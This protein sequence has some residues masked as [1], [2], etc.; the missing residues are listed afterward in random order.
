MRMLAGISRR[1]HGLVHDVQT[2]TLHSGMQ[3]VIS[4]LLHELP[5]D[6]ADAASIALASMGFGAPTSPGGLRVTLP[7]SKATIASRLS[8]TPEHFSRVLHMLEE[9]GLIVIDKRD[10]HIPDAARLAAHT[11]TDLSARSLTP[12]QAHQAAATA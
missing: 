4:Y 1:L 9:S 10:I 12:A 6:S 3:R 8:I 2:Y 5:E 11:W 7:V